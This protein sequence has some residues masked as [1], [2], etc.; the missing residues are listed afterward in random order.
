MID[1]HCLSQNVYIQ[2]TYFQTKTTRRNSLPTLSLTPSTIQENNKKF[3]GKSASHLL[4]IFWAG[5]WHKIGP[6]RPFLWKKLQKTTEIAY[7]LVS[8]LILTNQNTNILAP[9]LLW[10]PFFCLYF[11]SFSSHHNQPPHVTRSAHIT[12]QLTN[13]LIS[14]IASRLDKTKTKI[15]IGNFKSNAP[16]LT[17]KN[18]FL[19]KV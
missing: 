3:W 18:I 7:S 9:D 15:K 8:L 1:I 13:F 11:L 17:L 16:N 12:Q 10:F 4:S 14:K 5:N 2:L 19:K 6:A